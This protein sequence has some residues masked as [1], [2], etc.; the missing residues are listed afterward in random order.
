ME[1]TFGKKD[2]EKEIVWHKKSRFLPAL[3]YKN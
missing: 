3:M 2:T 1:I